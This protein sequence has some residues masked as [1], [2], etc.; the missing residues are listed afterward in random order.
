[1]AYEKEEEKERRSEYIMQK[2]N[3]GE[4]KR[5]VECGAIRRAP[6]EAS[7][8]VILVLLTGLLQ[9]PAAGSRHEMK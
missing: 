7:S 5:K 1:M 4:R 3:N 9:A 2:D 8:A 6:A